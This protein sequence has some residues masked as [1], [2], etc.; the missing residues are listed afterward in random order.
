MI[1]LAAVLVICALLFCNATPTIEAKSLTALRISAPSSAQVKQSFSI[2][3][4]LTA[5]GAPL[6]KQTVSLQRLSGKTWIALTSTQTATTGSYSFSRTETTANTYQYRTTYAGSTS[7]ASATSSTAAV[8]VKPATISTALTI[9]ASSPDQ[10]KQ[11]FSIS[12]QLTANGASLTK[13]TVSLQRLS[14]TTWTTLASQTAT[15]GTYSFSRTETTANTY[16]YRTTYAGSTTY[17]SSTSPTA[18]VAVTAADPTPTATPTPDPTATPTTTPSATPTPTA[19]PSAT[20]TPTPTATPTTT[21][22][23]APSNT[24][25]AVNQA[26]TLSG[27]L[28]SNG[29]PLSGKTIR[30]NVRDPSGNW[31][32]W[33]NATTTDANGAYT[34]ARSES[35]SGAYLYQTFFAGDT[36]YAYS[37]ALVTLTVGART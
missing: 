32:S 2:T 24:S 17:A 21:M 12:G 35:A 18:T 16:K 5:N 14:G 7:Y 34:F 13:Q 23:I 26:F 30:L 20:P 19:T 11:S 33:V 1:V 27:T 28:T 6:T 4:T 9:S 37:N 15:S 31:S 29:T 8:T 3:G 25:P 10:V 22:T 36:S